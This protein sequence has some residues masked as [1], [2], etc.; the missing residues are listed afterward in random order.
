M[1][2]WMLNVTTVSGTVPPV[3]RQGEMVAPGTTTAGG[4]VGGAGA[5]LDAVLSEE[6]TPEAGLVGRLGVVVGS[7][8]SRPG[9]HQA[10]SSATRVAVASS[11][12]SPWVRRLMGP[13]SRAGGYGQDM[14]G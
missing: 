6:E 10:M 1:P 11:A 13:F 14:R 12:T 8:G 7:P 4:A 9:A 5:L 2:L 3:R